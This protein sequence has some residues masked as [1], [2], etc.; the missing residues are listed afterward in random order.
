MLIL[1]LN[2]NIYHPHNCPDGVAS[3]GED[4]LGQLAWM[5]AQMSA[6]EEQGLKV[7]I[8]GHIPPALEAYSR[9]ANWVPA[10]SRQYWQLVERHAGVLSGHFFGHWHSAEVRLPPISASSGAISPRSRAAPA[11][12]VLSA[13]SPIYESNPVFYAATFDDGGRILQPGRFRQYALDLSSAVG[14]ETARFVASARAAPAQG[15]SNEDYR[16]AIASWLAPGGDAAFAPYWG[17]RKNY[18]PPS[19]TSCN[20]TGANFDLCRTCTGGCRVAFACL[21]SHGTDSEDFAA[22]LAANT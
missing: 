7:Q 6:A 3:C 20:S 1:V 8:H 10:Y 14:G 18:H 5:G 2:T 19:A 16:A 15:L 17:Q 4:P 13:I 21:Q 11:L 9:R 22:C 12:Q